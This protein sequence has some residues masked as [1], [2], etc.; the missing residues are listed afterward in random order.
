MGSN[1]SLIPQISNHH[2]C[3]WKKSFTTWNVQH[4]NYPWTGTINSTLYESRLVWNQHVT[5][6]QSSSSPFRL[7]AKKVDLS[8]VSRLGGFTYHLWVEIY[9]VYIEVYQYF[10]SILGSCLYW[11]HFRKLVCLNQVVF[12]SPWT[13]ESLKIVQIFWWNWLID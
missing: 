12:S 2:Y 7:R 8:L 10:R 1:Y 5:H 3:W 11:C 6:L 4:L 13:K 9:H